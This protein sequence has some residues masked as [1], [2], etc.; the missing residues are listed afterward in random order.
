[1]KE[2]KFLIVSF[3]TLLLISSCSSSSRTSV[4]PWPGLFR[5]KETNKKGFK[6]ERKRNRQL[7]KLKKKRLKTF[8][9]FDFKEIEKVNLA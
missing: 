1:M 2:I 8:N 9:Y 4:D 3:C 6:E 7:K 5:L